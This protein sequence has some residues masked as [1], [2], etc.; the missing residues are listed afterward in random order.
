MG[1]LAMGAMGFVLG[2]G[3]MLL[4][5]GRTVRQKARVAKRWVKSKM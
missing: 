3:M 5:A 1:K 2:A 4:P